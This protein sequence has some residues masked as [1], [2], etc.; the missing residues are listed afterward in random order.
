MTPGKIV[1]I[2][3]GVISV[4]IAIAYLVLVQLLDLRG[5]MLPAPIV[6]MIPGLLPRWWG[7]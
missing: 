7:V 4:L 2:I 3:T 1:A 5:E 6:E